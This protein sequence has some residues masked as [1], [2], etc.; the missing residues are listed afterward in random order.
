MNK[1]L[2]FSVFAFVTTTGSAHASLL[3]IGLGST[4]SSI[5]YSTGGVLSPDVD[6]V[7]DP[8]LV[9]NNNASIV[10]VPVSPNPNLFIQPSGSIYGNGFL[11]VAGLPSP[12]TGMATFT[13]TPNNNKLGFTWGTIDDY[14]S[15]IITDSRNVTYTITGTDILNQLLGSINHITQNDVLLTDNFGTIKTA[16]FESINNNSFEIANIQDAPLPSAVPLPGAL[17]LFGAAF[18][19][20]FAWSRLKAAHEKGI[21]FQV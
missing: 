5:S 7:G 10:T 15:L 6:M 3:D 2:Y 17:P 1:L 12:T 11:V 14:N 8:R 18:L 21:P 13:E 4:S 19:G 20:M 16:V 9:L